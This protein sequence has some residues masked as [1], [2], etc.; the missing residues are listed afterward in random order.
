MFE[1]HTQPSRH[2]CVPSEE[3]VTA[4]TRMGKRL[5]SGSSMTCETN[6]DAVISEIGV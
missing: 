6:I 2:S 4:V 3:R 1:V 5:H